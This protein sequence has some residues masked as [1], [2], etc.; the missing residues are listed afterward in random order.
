[1]RKIAAFGAFALALGATAPAFA[2]CAGHSVTARTT[3]MD[4]TQTAQTTVKTVLPSD[5][6]KGG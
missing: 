6:S 4:T 2:G 1:M 5:Q 3:V